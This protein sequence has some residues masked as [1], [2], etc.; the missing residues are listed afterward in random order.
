ML[1]KSLPLSL[2][3][4]NLVTLSGKIVLFDDLID[5]LVLIVWQQDIFV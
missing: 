5:D 1:W 2:L 3:I 4:G